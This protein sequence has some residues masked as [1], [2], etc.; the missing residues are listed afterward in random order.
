MVFQLDS[1]TPFCGSLAQPLSEQRNSL[2]Q[3][4][5]MNMAS[6]FKFV[7]NSYR[8]FPWWNSSYS[9]PLIPINP[10][11]YEQ[12]QTFQG[13]W[14]RMR[15][16]DRILSQVFVVILAATLVDVVRAVLVST[17]GLRYTSTRSNKEYWLQQFSDRCLKALICHCLWKTCL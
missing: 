12:H 6:A 3:I 1:M 7:E 5:S 10:S 17:V 14:N 9:V 16:F 2:I 11:F 8:H 13:I 4:Q 15:K